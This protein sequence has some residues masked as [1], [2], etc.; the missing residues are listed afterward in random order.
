MGSSV[1]VRLLRK[2]QKSASNG[3]LIR[4]S[5]ILIVILLFPLLVLGGL[6]FSLYL[7]GYALLTNGIGSMNGK[8]QFGQSRSSHVWDIWLEMDGRKLK[9]RF[10]AEIRYG[11][12]YFELQ[13]EPPIPALQGGFYGD[14]FC[15]FKNGYLLQ[16]WNLVYECNTQ[17]V[18][19]N[20]VT[21]EY[22]LL[23]ENIASVLWTSRRDE[24]G[25]LS[26]HCD[27]GSEILVFTLEEHSDIIWSPD[28]SLSNTE[29]SV[30]DQ[31]H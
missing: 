7:I 31:K 30:P 29:L 15:R 19:L 14:W 20:M 11:P 18:Y 25:S 6:L 28:T 23:L 13:A 22:E 26:L 4:L 9:R 3:P 10:E 16:K 12:S 21:G 17:L 2:V 24:D 8:S 27:T 1:H 5:L